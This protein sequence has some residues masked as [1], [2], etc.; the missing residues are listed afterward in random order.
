MVESGSR[1]VKLLDVAGDGPSNGPCFV[2]GHNHG[3]PCPFFL[4]L[5]CRSHDVQGA[6]LVLLQGGV[7]VGVSAGDGAGVGGHG[8]A[9]G[10]LLPPVRLPPCIE[11]QRLGI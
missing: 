5:A 1:L 3:G 9:P 8:E 7:L 10:S 11:R 6:G 2:K 4:L